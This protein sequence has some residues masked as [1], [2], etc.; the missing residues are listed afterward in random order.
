MLAASIWWASA[1]LACG[2]DM[3]LPAE[4][5]DLHGWGRRACVCPTA[6][7]TQQHLAGLMVAF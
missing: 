4:P 6:S 7:S 3:A 2:Q 5:G 1:L